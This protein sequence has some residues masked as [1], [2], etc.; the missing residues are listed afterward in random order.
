MPWPIRIEWHKMRRKI[1]RRFSYFFKSQRT[2]LNIARAD[3][4]CIYLDSML[5][6]KVCRAVTFSLV[7][8]FHC[9]KWRRLTPRQWNKA[10]IQLWYPL[11]YRAGWLWSANQP[12]HS[13][14]SI[15]I[16][17]IYLLRMIIEWILKPHP[18]PIVSYSNWTYMKATSNNCI[19]PDEISLVNY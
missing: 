4:N 10:N 5:H 16:V 3:R 11:C 15:G 18:F 9:P 14:H 8:A 19:N 12:N 1:C 13:N 7:Y 17:R 2:V 6:E